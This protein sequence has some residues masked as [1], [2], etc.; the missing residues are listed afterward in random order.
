MAADLKFDQF[1]PG[2]DAKVGD[3]VVGLRSSDLTNNYKFDFPGT[4]VRDANGNVMLQWA[5][6][7]ISAVN[8]P[9][10]INSL[11]GNSIQYTAEGDDV[12]IGIEIKPKGVGRLKLDDINWP[13]SAGVVGSFLYMSNATDIDF[14][15][16]PVVT[17]LIGTANQV[18][19]NGTA[20]VPQVGGVVTVSSPQDIA[21]TSSPT[22][23]D[24]TLTIPLPTTSGGTGN[25][26]WTTNGLV[27]ASSTSILSQITPVNSAVLISDPTGLPLFSGTMTNGQ[28]I[29]GSTG[30][31]PAASNITPGSGIGIV[32]G[33]GSITISA[34][35]G[36]L[37][38][39][40]VLGTTQAMTIDSGYTANNAGLVTLTL[41]VTAAYGTAISIIG[42]GAGGWLIA[43]NAGQS[44]RFGS[45]TTTIGVG[46][47]LASTNSGD[48]IDLIC[49][50]ADTVWSVRGAPQGIIT[51]V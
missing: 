13:I 48:S 47:S 19:V 7:G 9:K 17:G 18:L 8:W 39:T 40:D 15:L 31:T 4:G 16:T 10:V 30:A 49:I 34:T 24:L 3:Q 23:A 22:F 42:K 28:I 2:G 45:S 38:W 14:T 1:Q 6:T 26:A 44:I 36:G 33:A 20:G 46:G 51:V 50:T 11:P 32:N 12:D 37:T 41:P 5:T 27:F 25:S 43:Q 35:G 29:I 21:T